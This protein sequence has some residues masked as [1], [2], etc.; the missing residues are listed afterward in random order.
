MSADYLVHCHA[1]EAGFRTCDQRS[2]GRGATVAPHH[3]G[4]QVPMRTHPNTPPEGLRQGYLEGV[5]LQLRRVDALC[6]HPNLGA[7]F[8]A[9]FGG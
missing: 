8:G 2:K 7:S 6:Q 5:Y 4:P 3:R 1:M 9:R